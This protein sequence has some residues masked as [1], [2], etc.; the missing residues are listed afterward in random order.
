MSS[1]RQRIAITGCGAVCGAGL[2]VDEIWAALR[3]GRSAVRPIQKWDATR[4]PIQVAAEVVG[5][6]NRTLVED[7]KLHKTISRT[8]LFGL[9]AARRAIEDSG[10]VEVR[11]VLSEAAAAVF[12]D[13]SGVFAGSGGGT[14][15][16]NYD[17]FPLLT[18]SAGELPAF[19]REL[20]ANVNPMW[21]L[22]NLP[23]NVLCHVGIRHGFKGTNAC[24]TNHCVSGVLAVAEAAAAIQAGEADR[25][26][27]VGHDAPVEPETVFHYAQAG[28]LSSAA[29]RPFS[30]DR[31]GTVLGEGA[32]ALML[33]NLDAAKE[34]SAAV[35]GEFL[36]SGCCGE[37]LG[38]VE[39]RPDG[40]GVT[41]AIALALEDAAID[42]KEV[43]LIV[44]HGNGTQISDAS[45]ALAIRAVFGDRPPPVTAF[46]WV[47]GHL[48][49]ASGTLDLALALKALRER[50]VPGIGTLNTLD[51]ELTPLPVAA[52]PQQ[53]TSD[54][55]VVLCRGFGST[56]VAVVI[57]AGAASASR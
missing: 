15:G 47:V 44:A 4:W 17:F 38:V 20:A 7:R 34:R 22:K 13:R 42:R 16:S 30:L 46:K 57:R 21:L 2:T 26:L 11:S 40:D 45:E 49:A 51:P 35:H 32:A 14:Y 54:I 29:L 27:A 9:Y 31:D 10:L 36:G 23:N 50:V 39:I 5:V 28:L 52:T 37:A 6:D 1:R 53:P 12:N 43:G 8:D 25:A 33:E 55:A 3:E 48:I 19:G 18:A 56:N 24:I 41:R